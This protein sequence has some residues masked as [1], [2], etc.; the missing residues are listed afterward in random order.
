MKSF[1]IYLVGESDS[2]KSSILS[3]LQNKPFNYNIA[4]TIGVDYCRYKRKQFIFEIYDTSGLAQFQQSTVNSMKNANLIIL[5]FDI[6]SKEAFQHIEKWL[7]IIQKSTKVIP[8]VLVGNK[9]DKSLQKK[10]EQIKGLI[11]N[12]ILHYTSAL[13]PKSVK[14][15][16]TNI[17]QDIINSD[18]NLNKT[19]IRPQKQD[20][21]ENKWFCFC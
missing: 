7:N 21:K 3:V 1:K 6:S 8:I 19:L 10:N 5:C 4:Q 14:D 11:Q 13:N 16:F 18:E 15:M 12:Y 2:G 20:Q 9:I 17:F